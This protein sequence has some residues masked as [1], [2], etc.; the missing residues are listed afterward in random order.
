MTERKPLPE[1]LTSQAYGLTKGQIDVIEIYGA[2]LERAADAGATSAEVW[3]DQRGM[4]RVEA[5]FTSIIISDQ[6][7]S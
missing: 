7:P 5:D 2:M 3:T 6:E 1:S 4:L